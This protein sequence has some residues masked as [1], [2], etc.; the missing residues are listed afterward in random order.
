MI[1][2]IGMPLGEFKKVNLL[3]LRVRSVGNSDATVPPPTPRGG[4]ENHDGTYP[5]LLSCLY[6][7]NYI[8]Y[9]VAAPLTE[10]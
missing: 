1:I 7:L 3:P 5:P 4:P 2:F 10:G 9:P 6:L 8:N